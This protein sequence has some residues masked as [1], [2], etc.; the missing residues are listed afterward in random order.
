MDEECPACAEEKKRREDEE[1]D[2]MLEH[3]A[4]RNQR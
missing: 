1:R 3:E 4:V 2:I